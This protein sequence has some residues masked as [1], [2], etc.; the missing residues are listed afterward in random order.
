GVIVV[1]PVNL[2]E[3]LAARLKTRAHPVAAFQGRLGEPTAASGE[4]ALATLHAGIQLCKD[5]RAG[6]LVTAPISKQALALAGSNDR[7]HTEILTRAMGKGPTAMAF[8][9]PR[10]RTVLVTVH[11]SLAGAIA[12]L[13]SARVLEVTKLFDEALRQRLGIAAP[14]LAL[15]ALNP[16]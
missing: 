13:S 2:A 4:A 15:A 9:S 6:A 16:H 11:V 1:G 7:G 8:F 10:L 12:Q 14:R 3:P 5:G